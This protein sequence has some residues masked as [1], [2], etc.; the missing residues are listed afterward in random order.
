LF[1]CSRGLEE[2][3]VAEH[4]AAA[5]T[6]EATRRNE[7]TEKTNEETRRNK[8]TATTKEGTRRDKNTETMK[9]ATRRYENTVTARNRKDEIRGGENHKRTTT[10]KGEWACREGIGVVDVRIKGARR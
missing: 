4:P 10:E 1:E 3:W 9:E 8:K 2:Y 6:K 5:T 7:K